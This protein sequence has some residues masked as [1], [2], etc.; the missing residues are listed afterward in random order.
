MNQ[1]KF[2]IQ[3]LEPD[4]AHTLSKVLENLEKEYG[5]EIQETADQVFVTALNKDGEKVTYGFTKVG[6]TLLIEGEKI[7]FS[8]LVAK[9]IEEKC[10]KKI[11]E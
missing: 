10:Q 3:K 6:D 1:E 8:R 5:A 4:E 11:A 2:E 7:N 9:T